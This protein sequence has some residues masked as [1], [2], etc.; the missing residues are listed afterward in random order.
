MVARLQDTPRGRYYR[1]RGATL[2][3]RVDEGPDD[4]EGRDPDRDDAT[5]AARRVSRGDRPSRRCAFRGPPRK[6]GAGPAIRSRGPHPRASDRQ[7][8]VREWG[9]DDLLV[10]RHG[11][12][13][14]VPRTAP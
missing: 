10:R 9:C 12:P 8:G 13:P 6:E 4:V 5:G 3:P 1:L 11:R 14:A 2:E 7:A